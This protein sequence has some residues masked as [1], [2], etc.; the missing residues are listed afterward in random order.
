MIK[1]FTLILAA[2]LPF[3]VK[4]QAPC[5]TTNATGCV[6]A[7]SGQT[8]CNLLP[9]ITISG[10]AILSYQSGPNEMAPNCG[11]CL[12]GY[13][14]LYVTGSTPNIGHGP[15][16][17]GAV[18]KWTCGTDTFTTFPG[19]CLD[20]TAPRQLIKQKIYH[21]SG[22]T[23]TF[24]E[25]WAGSMTY[26]QTHGHM[27]V[28]D[29]GVFTLRIQD[30]MEPDAR[31]W[32]IVGS[33]AKLGFCLMDYYQCGDAAADGHCRN[34]AGDTL[35][36]AD[37]P[38]F[39]LGGGQYNCSPAEQGISSGYTDVY[40]ENLDGM[41]IDIP[42]GTC[43]GNYYIVIEVDPHNFFTEE[44]ENNNW[45][46]V[47]FTLTQQTAPGNASASISLPG[48]ST[49]CTG[50]SIT[51]TA[52]AGSVFNWSTGATTQSITVGQAGNYFVEVTTP[53][54]TATSDT[55]AIAI[56]AAVPVPTTIGD[57]ACANQS[58]N[59]TATASTGSVVWF[60]DPTAGNLV[61][62]GNSFATPT[63]ATTTTY[64]AAAERV[65]PGTT[66]FAGKVDSV[67]GGGNLNSNSQY[68]IF[69]ATTDFTL[70]SVKVYSSAAGN[71]T[72]ELRNTT[73]ITLQTITLNVPAGVSRINLNFS[74]PTGNNY[75]LQPTSST[76]NM[77]RNNAG[78][79]YPYTVANVASVT[80][81]SGG[82]NF[83]YYF[84]DWEVETSPT[85]C[86][87]NRVAT[88]ATMNP[89]PTPTIT[90]LASAYTILDP[91]V[92]MSGTPANGT[93]TGPGVTGSVFDPAIAGVGMHAITYTFTDANN[94]TGERT[95]SVN[96]TNGVGIENGHGANPG[97][98]VFPN[99][100]NGLFNLRFAVTEKTNVNIQLSTLTG[101]QLFTEQLP[102]FSGDY[103]RSLDMSHL[104]HGVYIIRIEA[105]GHTYFR[106]LV[107]N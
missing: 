101:A 70:K 97:I 25:H 6:C 34:A 47:P 91:A 37:F 11:A 22:N 20:G 57:I 38:N 1:R 19:T 51:L 3:L 27:H 54:G 30:P 42:P 43:N 75:R 17:V 40:N 83:Y 100:N 72:I 86:Y 99:P 106:K 104:A 96:I 28:D 12:P 76:V 81:S 58:V 68:L 46:A 31:N 66:H 8:D 60:D 73:G 5:T 65:T 10:N 33:G 84:F 52:N 16:T 7:T 23:M 98:Y 14:R 74:V 69:N 41:W 35:I 90:G 50:D 64:Y 26:H 29:W 56:L 24:A 32:P 88:I 103:N 71:R 48:P 55:Q 85:I 93:F 36:N 21:K 95:D 59:L 4:A 39:G 82:A 107:R 44:D 89:L 102:N 15:L 105:G 87:S 9:D 77:F 49:L 80:G 67:G 53:C 78:V 62:T 61:H 2:L 79:S 18:S 92:T 94:C 13:G 45:T 63:L